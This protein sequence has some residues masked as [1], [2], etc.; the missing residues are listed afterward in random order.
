MDFAQ[1]GAI[2]HRAGIGPKHRRFLRVPIPEGRGTLVDFLTQLP[3][4]TSII[5]LQYGRIDSA[6]QYPVLGLIGSDQEY[7]DLDGVLQ[8]RGVSASDVSRDEDVD[9]RIINYAA[10][11]FSFSSVY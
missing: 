10:E 3:S 4:E 6:V 5:D 2:A 1:L 9:Y 8:Q 11:L 7:D